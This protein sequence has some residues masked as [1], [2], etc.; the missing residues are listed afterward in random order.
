MEEILHQLIG[1]SSHYL[2]GFICFIHVKRWCRISSINSIIRTLEWHKCTFNKKHD[3]FIFFIV[4]HNSLSIFSLWE[5]YSTPCRSVDKLTTYQC[6]FPGKLQHV[7]LLEGLHKSDVVPSREL[8]YPPK[9]HIWRWF[10][11]SPG[12]IC[13]IIPRRVTSTP[14]KYQ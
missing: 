12:G 5:V 2:Q 13:Y 1:S 6:R 3:I 4:Q 11:F 9:W 10:S 8:T 14:L 7:R